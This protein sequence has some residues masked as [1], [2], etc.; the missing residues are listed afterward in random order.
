[1]NLTVVHQNTNKMLTARGYSFMTKENDVYVYTNASKKL[2]VWFFEND[3][4][5]IDAIKDFVMILE[6]MKIKHGIVIYR[7]SVTSSTKKILEQMYKFRIELFSASE[8]K[9]CLTDH[10]YYVPHRR[11]K[12]SDTEDIMK[13]FGTGL[14]ILLRTDPVS[15]YFNFVKN[16]IVEITRKNGSI[17]YRVVK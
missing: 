1:M 3:K 5:N 15:R 11:L 14:P 17:A 8:F 6:E 10:M 13:R 4:L 9:Y 16:D 7:G 2:I 12:V